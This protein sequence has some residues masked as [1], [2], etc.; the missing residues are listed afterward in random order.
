MINI[1][2]CDYLSLVGQKTK[3]QSLIIDP[4]LSV[5]FILPEYKYKYNYKYK[6]ILPLYYQKVL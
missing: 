2:L 1:V 4:I 6:Y 3:D 5:V